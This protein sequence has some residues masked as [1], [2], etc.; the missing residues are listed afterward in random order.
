[1]PGGS[2]STN[3]SSQNQFQNSTTEPLLDPN[4]RALL[5]QSVYSA[6]G[7]QGAG[8]LGLPEQFAPSPM[9]VAPLGGDELSLIRAIE[10]SAGGNAAAA[11]HELQSANDFMGQ[12]SN[13]Y[14]RAASFIDPATGQLGGAGRQLGLANRA[15]A[16]AAGDIANAQEFLKQLSGAPIQGD[17]TAAEAATGNIGGAQSEADIASARNRL[18][19]LTSGDIGSS[20][21]TAAAMRAYQTSALPQIIAGQ[22]MAGPGRGGGLAQAL[23]QGEEQAYVPLVQQEIQNRMTAAPEYAALGSE[24]SQLAQARAAGYTNLADFRRD[25]AL[26]QTQGAESLAGARENLAG[27]RQGLAGAREQ[28]AGGYGNLANLA[29]GIGSE[30]AGLAGLAGNLAGGYENLGN[31]QQEQLLRALGVASMPRDIQNQ[32]FQNQYQDMLRRY[33]LAQETALGPEEQLAQLLAGTQTTGTTRD[34]GTGTQAP[35]L[36]D[37]LIG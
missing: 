1:M 17:I 2:T 31:Y 23:T 33:G 15:L 27:A 14:N 24:E 37:Y 4:L 3:K 29:S 6:R 7:A 32:V 12:A 19:Q 18:N 10:N 8:A 25:L 26:A 5:E 13:Y 35:S 16:P 20:P 30:K 36:L 21:A 28:L 11:G 34:T 22:A 9:G